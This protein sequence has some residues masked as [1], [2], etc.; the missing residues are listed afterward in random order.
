[1]IYIHI[2]T[3]IPTHIGSSH[4]GYI[5]YT[6]YIKVVA[7]VWQLFFLSLEAVSFGS[8]SKGQN[9]KKNS[10]CKIEQEKNHKAYYSSLNHLYTSF[11]ALA[12]TDTCGF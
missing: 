1:M 6:I 4:L 11:I 7:D 12:K 5:F 10:R 9:V 2:G 8:L 3:Y